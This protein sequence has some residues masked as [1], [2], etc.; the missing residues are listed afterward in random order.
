MK[1]R[2]NT[3]RPFAL[4][5]FGLVAGA[6]QPSLIQAQEPTA[7]SPVI[8][9][10][11]MPEGAANLNITPR[12]IMFDE[13]K[14]TEAVYVFNQGTTPITV[15]VALVDNVMMP[16]GAIVPVSQLGAHAE[17]DRA[18]AQNLQSARDS[19]LATPSRL[20]LA[21]GK[22]KTVRIRATLPESAD[23]AIEWRSHLT[24]TTVPTTDA[25][26]TAEAA[27]APRQGELSFRIQSVFGISI[28][29]IVRAGNPQAT[30][31]VESISLEQAS[32]TSDTKLG[33]GRVA[34]LSFT[35]TRSG[36]ASIYGNIEVSASSDKPG[37]LTGFVRGI[38]VYPEIAGRRVSLALKRMP[39]PGD[40]LSIV[41]VSDD[42]QPRRTMAA[43]SF[44]VR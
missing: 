31:G 12:R 6:M 20:T 41:L 37:E 15:D 44:N 2:A 9:Q 22:G 26:L 18:V 40:I 36:D 8:T 39:R 30:A 24:V 34:I 17:N 25:G 14:R 29:A 43:A 5:M 11:G 7:P 3:S 21:P 33:D 42:G 4:T 35:L 27:A 13:T 28:P 38:A 32:P 23:Q 19:L 10:M 16:S 1:S